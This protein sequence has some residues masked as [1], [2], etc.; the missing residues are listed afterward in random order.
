MPVSGLQLTTHNGV[1]RPLFDPTQLSNSQ[2]QVALGGLET[3][4]AGP[5]RDRVRFC[6]LKMPQ[7]WQSAVGGWPLWQGKLRDGGVAWLKGD[8]GSKATMAQK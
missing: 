4:M 7:F 8:H 5:Q 6:S 3:F 1:P 2:Q